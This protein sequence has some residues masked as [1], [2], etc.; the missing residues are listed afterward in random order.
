[1]F[2]ADRLVF[3]ELHKTGGT[4]IGRWLGELVGGEQIGKHNRLPAALADRFI[5]GSVRNPW[6]WYVSLWAYGCGGEGSV[7]VQTTRRLSFRYCHQQ[8]AA[9]MGRDRAGPR[10]WLL[11]CGHD[12][13]KPV[14]AWRSCYRDADDA[15]AFRRWLHMLLD[16]ARRFDMAEG[17]GFS[18]VAHCGGLMTYRYLKLFTRLGDSLY[19]DERLARP[20]G[21]REAWRDSRLVSYLV[22]NEHLEDDLLE[23]LERAGYPPR[24]EQREALLQARSRKTNSSRRRS[25][26]FYYDESSIEL[27]ARR[28]ALIIEEHG[29][30]PPLGIA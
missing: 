23:A 16:P 26:D 24:A 13:V 25:T 14:A 15:R 12:L 10:E 27:V 19:R 4:H 9:E 18:P 20:Q 3:L 5:L 1:M 28:E 21:L 17:Y 22:R 30:Q 2:V 11:Q 8:L 7:Y 6:D 29:Y